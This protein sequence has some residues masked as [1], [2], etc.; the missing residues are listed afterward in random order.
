[1]I[2]YNLTIENT[3]LINNVEYTKDE[4]IQGLSQVRSQHN[5]RT[6]ESLSNAEWLQWSYL[7]NLAAWFNYYKDNEV[8]LSESI[9]PSTDWQLLITLLEPYFNIGLN[10][11]YVVF[12]QCFNM[13]LALKR[14]ANFNP[15][16]DEWKN[17]AFNLN[18]GKD[19]FN[20]IQKAEIETIFKQVNI[21]LTFN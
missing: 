5:K 8:I 2:T 9:T 6:G 3:Q 21:P 19:A 11:N 15:N 18:L 12:T 10:A 20:A 16:I 13:L 17:F 7:Q 4:L 14:T 1:M